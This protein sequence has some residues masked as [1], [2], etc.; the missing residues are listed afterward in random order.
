MQCRELTGVVDIATKPILV[1][2]VGLTERRQDLI[3]R[4][5]RESCRE[6]VV[7]VKLDKSTNYFIY[8]STYVLISSIHPLV[9]FVLL[10]LVTIIIIIYYHYHHYYCSLFALQIVQRVT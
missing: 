8:N 3:T 9:V 4:I 2:Y 6:R 7:W 5:L 10:L 1:K